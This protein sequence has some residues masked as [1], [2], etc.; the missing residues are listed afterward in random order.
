[1]SKAA[2]SW[3]I[4]AIVVVA[5][6]AGGGKAATGDHAR[7]GPLECD[8]RTSYCEIFLSDVP[9]IPTNYFCRP[10]PPACLPGEGPART[11]DCFPEETRCRTFCGPLP[12][13][14]GALTGFHLTC[15]GR[16]P[17]VE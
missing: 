9:E 1:M 4:V 15:Q 8:V 12:T 3:G 2:A 13:A 11:C 17:P 10:L 16:R 7:C 6:K 14:S 5:C